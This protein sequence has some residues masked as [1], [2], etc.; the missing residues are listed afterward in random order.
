VL[1]LER[2]TEF[3]KERD[4]AGQWDFPSMLVL[5]ISSRPTVFAATMGSFPDLRSSAIRVVHDEFSACIGKSSDEHKVDSELAVEITLC[6]EP[7]SDSNGKTVKAILPISLLQSSCVLLS[8]WL[9]TDDD[10]G[11]GKAVEDLVR[12][13]M[14]PQGV[15][16]EDEAVQDI[17]VD[18]LASA[19]MSSSG[20]NAIPVESVSLA[21]V[22][23]VLVITGLRLI[24]FL[25]RAVGYAGSVSQ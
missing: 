1:A 3:A 7:S 2:L 20:K 4:T 8:I 6:C 9:E 10:D 5:L 21:S 22:V 18:G 13:L 11:G 14:R 23:L 19:K 17:K 16:G 15:Y 12:M 25:F 24:N